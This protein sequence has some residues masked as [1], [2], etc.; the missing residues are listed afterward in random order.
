[1]NGAGPKLRSQAA[2]ECVYVCVSVRM[3]SA[4]ALFRPSDGQIRHSRVYSDACHCAMGRRYFNKNI[5][6]EPIAATSL[7][8]GW[9]GPPETSGAAPRR[10]V[11]RA[12]RGRAWSRSSV[13]GVQRRRGPIRIC[14]ALLGTRAHTS[15][16]IAL[17][18][19]LIHHARQAP[20]V[21]ALAPVGANW[22]LGRR[23]RAQDSRRHRARSVR[24]QRPGAGALRAAS[25]RWL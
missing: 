20:P 2:F 24:S 1:M 9:R 12:G 8:S 23:T 10:W 14:A 13:A 11:W 3:S 15:A 17:A 6:R 4:T 16:E 19:Q 25:N 18:R 21:S 22:S 5:A 7:A